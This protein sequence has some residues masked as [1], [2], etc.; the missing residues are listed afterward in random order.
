VCRDPAPAA[1]PPH[2][3]GTDRGAGPAGRRRAPAAPWSDARRTAGLLPAF[4]PR[5][6]YGHTVVVEF[7]RGTSTVVTDSGDARSG[8]ARTRDRVRAAVLE[9]GPVTATSLAARL[10]LTAAAV[11]RHL[12]AL[13]GAG[14]VEVREPRPGVRGRGRPAREYLLTELGHAQLSSAYD[15]LAADALAFLADVAGPGA[16][17]RFAERRIADLERRYRPVVDEAGDD[18]AARAG[19]LAQALSDD[20]YAASTRGT[21]AS[22][23]PQVR[24]AGPASPG[25]ASRGPAPVGPAA[26]AVPRVAGFQLCQG[27]CPVQHVAA[28]FP[29]LCEAET[30]AFSRLL[31]VH[32][33]RLA[34]LAHGEHVC[35]THI[36]FD[37]AAAS[38]HSV[39][40]PGVADIRNRDSDVR[41]APPGAP[42]A[43]VRAG[44]PRPAPHLAPAPPHPSRD[45]RTTRP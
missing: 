19:A 8:D 29:Q 2:G 20:G 18:V 28:R 38:G 17:E 14:Q 15:D 24:A 35:T 3:A 44:P 43:T 10:G 31:G 30:Q 6:E 12:D 32:V 33:Q 41:G 39:R 25:P 23:G 7:A 34:T 40:A 42:Q 1:E 27:H 11:R 9:R 36:P 22:T 4:E 37:S 26:A 13:V 16:V 21:A 45:G 5:D